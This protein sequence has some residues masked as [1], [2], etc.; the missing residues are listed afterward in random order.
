MKQKEYF[1]I[2]SI[3]NLDSIIKKYRPEKIFLV[4]GKN[5]YALSGAQ[6]SIDPILRQYAVVHFSEISSN[7]RLEDIKRGIDIFRKEHCDMVIAVG[8]GRTI[9]IAKSINSLA[10][11]TGVPEDY[12]TGIKTLKNKGKTL[13]AIPTTAGTGSEATHFA[14]VYFEGIKYSLEHED[15]I[16]PDYAIIDPQFT[17]NL[18]AEITASSGMDALCQGI[19]SFWSV[20]STEESKGYAKESIMLSLKNLEKVVRNPIPE[21]RI[22]MSRAANLSGKAINISKTT[23]S[24]AISYPITYHFGVSHGQAVGLTIGSMIVFNS[25]ITEEDNLDRRGVDYVRK[26]IGE[27]LELLSVLTPEEARVSIKNLMENI[28]LHT[29]LNEVGI[30]FK[31]NIKLIMNGFSPDRAKNN[32][33][34]I[35]PEQ[36]T[37]ILEEIE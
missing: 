4:T 33:R 25:K 7:P 8:G 24:H 23:A 5:A 36:L 29:K 13:V 22:A 6:R 20:N 16:I 9:D 27:L 12:I 19:E 37:Q 15:F 28:G 26:N 3:R 30:I 17:F 32:P 18:S 31:K 2:G 34:Q 11:Q 35:N 14:T 1:G 21:S 10:V